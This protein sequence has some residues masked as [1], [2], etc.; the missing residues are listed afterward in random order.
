MTRPSGSRDIESRLIA[1]LRD[2]ARRN[3]PDATPPPRFQSDSLSDLGDRPDVPKGAWVVVV[4]A[5]AIV[6]AVMLALVLPSR[7]PGSFGPADQGPGTFVVLHARTNGLSDAE[8]EEARQVISARAVAL[9]AA[10]P[11]VRIVGMNE[12]TAFLPG[13]P[14][15]AVKD[16]GVVDALQV[17]PVVMPWAAS[18][19]PAKPPPASDHPVDPWKSLGFAPPKDAAAYRE[20]SLDQRLAVQAV[21]NNWNCN[22]LPVDR[23]DVPIVTCDQDRNERYMLGPALA[24]SNEITSVTAAANPDAVSFKWELA[25]TMKPAA[26]SRFNDYIAQFKTPEVADTLDSVVIADSLVTQ[27]T[28]DSTFTATWYK[29]YDEHAAIQLAAFLSCGALPDLFDVVSTQRR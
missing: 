16:L 29:T 9:G 19:L 21:V 4:L 6:V 28:T 11:D 3:L 22:D 18:R 24:A 5:A 13:V 25:L 17:R 23:A 10:N 15:S 27:P 12:I 1:A 20:L 8:L 14:V 2:T 7:G 26:N